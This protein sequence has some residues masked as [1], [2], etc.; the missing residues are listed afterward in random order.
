MISHKMIGL[1]ALT[2][3][4]TA[5]A[6]EPVYD[7]DGTA[8]RIT[9][10]SN[11]PVKQ[12]E[13]RSSSNYYMEALVYAQSPTIEC[14]MAELI[15]ESTQEAFSTIGLTPTPFGFVVHGELPKS[16]ETLA[17]ALK[18]SCE[19]GE[20]SFTVFHKVPASPSIQLQPDLQ[21]EEWIPPYKYRPGFFLNLNYQAQAYI[22]NHSSD[23]VCTSNMLT[24][25]LPEF[26]FIQDGK[27]QFISDSF[28][29]SG[30]GFYTSIH[31]PYFVRGITCSNAGG[32][33]ILTEEWQLSRYQ[34]ND[35]S[36][37][38]TESYD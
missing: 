28:E 31:S 7:T 22:D 33:T 29:V 24:G 2:V 25:V 13:V 35:I 16:N 8:T 34:P 37:N 6:A 20:Q 9:S 36:L 21:G 10:Y 32:K 19:D 1:L 26:N 3:S 18:I 14:T 27:S 23:G 15:S 30:K 12:I 17:K 11:G 4:C 38:I 5:Q